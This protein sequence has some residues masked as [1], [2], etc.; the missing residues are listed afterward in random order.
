MKKKL[1]PLK[2]ASPIG[3]LLLS[4]TLFSCQSPSEKAAPTSA[5]VVDIETLSSDTIRATDLRFVPLESTEE[6]LVSNADKLFFVQDTYYVMDQQGKSILLFSATGKFLSKINRVGRGP[7]EYVHLTDVDV[8]GDGRIWVYDMMTQKIVRYSRKGALLDEFHSGKLCLGMAA[9]SSNDSIVYLSHL[10]EQ[11]H[12]T[13]DLAKYNLY[14]REF[15]EILAHEY[16]INASVVPFIGDTFYRVGNVLLHYHRFTPHIYKIE[17]DTVSRYVTMQSDQIPSVQQ[18]QEWETRYNS[19][20]RPL[21]SYG[22]ICALGF[23]FENSDHLLIAAFEYQP[24]LP[25]YTLLDR[26]HPTKAHN[27]FSLPKV[28]GIGT[29]VGMAENSFIHAFS[30]SPDQISYLLEHCPE[31]SAQTVR[32]LSS[33]K[34]DDNPVL[35]LFELEIKE[36]GE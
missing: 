16:A 7:G 6:S 36:S 22:A 25:R 10:V 21:R 9:S 1:T 14:T 8:T 32:L 3:L 13:T 23:C 28:V 26:R 29:I 30:P 31:L 2:P 11:G 4:L 27:I 15:T 17:G 34:E 20:R 24:Y 18:L 35:T 5:R 19:S 12:V 33:L